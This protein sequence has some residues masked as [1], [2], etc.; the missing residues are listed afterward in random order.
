MKKYSGINYEE[1]HDNF[2]LFENIKSNL[3]YGDLEFIKK[4]WITV[5]IPTYKRVEL[6]REA[7]E[8]VLR[9]EHV[10]FLWDILVLDNEPCELGK[11]NETEQYIRKLNNPRIIYY[12]N[13]KNIGI[14]GNYNRCIELARGEW[15]SFLHSDDLLVSSYLKQIAVLI[16]KH[17][18]RSIK[19]L[20]YISCPHQYFKSFNLHK[21]KKT[22]EELKEWEI[23][24]GNSPL[25]GRMARVLRY[26]LLFTGSLGIVIPTCGTLIY[27]RAMLEVGGYNDDL[28]ISEDVIIPW[29][30]MKNYAVYRSAVPLGFYRWS[31]T[32]TSLKADTNYKIEENLFDFREYVYR[33]NIFSRLMGALFRQE[34]FANE[35]NDLLY[36]AK[37][38]GSNQP[39]EQ[40]SDI[41]KYKPSK[42]RKL[43][44][45]FVR[46]MYYRLNWFFAK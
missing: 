32:N 2:K 44:F 19:P 24:F 1:Y 38:A 30:I 33:K 26:E 14:V 23:E 11:Q 45:L 41:L 22:A 7:V 4:P 39:M 36:A 6:L 40:F 12:R 5:A 42:F 34:H 31:S 43:L 15:I 18:K 9:Q 17:R 37:Y 8:S 3:I 46:K 20:G 28:G 29:L 16:K 25:R 27:R 35:V 10:D 21:D 13:Q